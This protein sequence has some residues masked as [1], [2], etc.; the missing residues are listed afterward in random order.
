MKFIKI[1]QKII[2]IKIIIKFDIFYTDFYVK[3][4]ILINLNIIFFENNLNFL[5]KC[6]FDRI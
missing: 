1:K 4:L 5:K 3:F 6:Q 2:Q